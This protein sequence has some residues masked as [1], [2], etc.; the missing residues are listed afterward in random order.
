MVKCNLF[1]CLPL[2]PVLPAE[3]DIAFIAAEHH[4][5]SFL[6]HSTIRKPR[7][8]RRLPAAPT[9]GLDLLDGVRPGQEPVRTIEQVPLEV[10]A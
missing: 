8:I 10:G 5:G 7:I 2:R 4:L 3:G 9:H 6:D 1:R